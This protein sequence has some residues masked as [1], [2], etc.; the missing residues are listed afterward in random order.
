[1]NAPS[2]N[3]PDET[4]LASFL[5]RGIRGP[6]ALHVHA[7]VRC[8]LCAEVCH[9]YQAE[10][11]SANVPGAKAAKTVALV[12]QIRRAI[13][14]AHNAEGKTVPEEFWAELGEVVF[15]RCTGCGRCAVHCSVGADATSIIRFG[16]QLVAAAGKLPSGL[17]TVVENQLVA[18]NQMAIPPEETLATAAWVSEDLRREIKDDRARVRIDETGARVLYLVNPREVKFFP[19]SLLAAA[20]VFHVAGEDWTM[21]SKFFDVTN[22]G[23]FAGDD[24]AARRIT[25]QIYAEA[26]R[27]GA[28]EIVLAECGHGY[29]SF[30]WEAATW[31]G[32]TPATPVRSILEVI[33]EYLKTGRIRVDKRKNAEP[34]TLHDPCNL[35]RWGG[36]IN[37]P[38]RILRAVCADFREMTP[39][40]L[41]NYCCGGGGGMLSLSE[42]GERRVASG[43][44]KAE[45]IRATGARVVATP[46]HNCA[47]QLLEINKKYKLGVRVVTVTELV[48]DALLL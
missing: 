28:E 29:R 3:S 43:K 20:G 33:E 37:T 13:K 23:F 6:A 21:S 11:E 1:M 44:K 27:L 5:N 12:R 17:K 41:D 30:R 35:A 36:V 22:Y 10:P 31:L 26:Q 32:K 9:I 47:D 18:G 39:H 8:G 4:D 15:G 46:C 34:V 24:V 40:G 45:Q 48:Y 19:L 42:Y 14:A 7:C 25:E 38:R 2:R 16:R